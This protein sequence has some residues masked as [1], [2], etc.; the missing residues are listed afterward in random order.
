[1][2]LFVLFTEQSYQ[3]ILSFLLLNTEIKLFLGARGVFNSTLP[4][5]YM[6]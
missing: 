2:I 4:K 1:M 3:P 6:D 5:E